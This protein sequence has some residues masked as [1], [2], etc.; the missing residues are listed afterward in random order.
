MSFRGDAG[1]LQSGKV[2]ARSQL[3]WMLRLIGRKKQVI[4]ALGQKAEFG[5]VSL[6]AG[7]FFMK[8]KSMATYETF[9]SVYD[10]IMNDSLYEVDGFQPA[11]FSQG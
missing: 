3:V 7:L 4:F 6:L 8:G 10:A 2:V 11:S 1:A 9:A 5:S